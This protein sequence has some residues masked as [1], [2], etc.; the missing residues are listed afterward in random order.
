MTGRVA[1]A[2]LRIDWSNSRFA[3]MWL[4][5]VRVGRGTVPAARRPSR[6]STTEI[7]THTGA[8]SIL[9]PM[10]QMNRGTFSNSRTLLTAAV[11]LS[12]SDNGEKSK[13]SIVKTG[14]ESIGFELVTDSRLPPQRT[15]R[16]QSDPRDR[17]SSLS[18]TRRCGGVSTS[19]VSQSFA[20]R[21]GGS[22]RVC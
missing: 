1:A 3:A 17:Y 9:H 18:N 22:G 13:A 15:D 7:Y 4:G 5:A 16:H 20:R 8:K 2:R 21:R 10:Y 12:T 19:A 11:C 14:Q 6:Q